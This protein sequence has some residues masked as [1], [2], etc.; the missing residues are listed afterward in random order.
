M[1]D[2]PQFPATMNPTQVLSVMDNLLTKPTWIHITS[3]HQGETPHLGHIQM[4]DGLQP[5]KEHQPRQGIPMVNQPIKDT[6]IRGRSSSNSRPKANPN[7]KAPMTQRGQTESATGFRAH[8]THKG[9]PNS[10]EQ[11]QGPTPSSKRQ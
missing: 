2:S 8:H 7:F 3:K 6:T 11:G 9:Q 5:G 1:E 10:P 4:Q